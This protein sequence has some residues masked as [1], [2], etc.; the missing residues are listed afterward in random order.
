MSSKKK[1]VK[2]SV[3]RDWTESI[4]IAF[5]LSLVIRMFFIQAYKIPT[6]SMR[7]TLQEGDLIFVNKFI[8]GAKVPLTNFYLPALRQPKRGDVIVFVYPEDKK[9]DFIKRLVGLPGETVEIKGGS[10]YINDQPAND[11]IFKQIYYY[12]RGEF[13]AEGQKIVVPADS[14][15]V[16]G[17]NSVTSKDSRYWGFVPKESILGKALI[18]YWPLH[19]IKLIK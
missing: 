14:Y 5:L 13:S 18:V 12:N 3:L 10:I 9:K 8:Y 4:I 16:L 11:P 15:F 6:G 2:K 7:M 17:D 1:P 19:R